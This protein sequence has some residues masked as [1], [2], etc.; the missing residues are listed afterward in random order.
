MQSTLVSATYSI[1]LWNSWHECARRGGRSAQRGG[2]GGH[3]APVMAAATCQAPATNQ[4]PTMA[5]LHEETAQ[6]LPVIA[7]ALPPRTAVAA[8]RLLH[9]LILLLL[10]PAPVQA[11]NDV[12][13]DCTHDL[14]QERAAR[15]DAAA[16][17]VLRDAVALTIDR[18]VSAG[19]LEQ[20]VG[21]LAAS[22]A[23]P[24]A[25]VAPDAVVAPVVA[26]PAPPLH[27]EIAADEAAPLESPNITPSDFLST[28]SGT[29]TAVLH[30]SVCCTFYAVYQVSD[31][32]R[33]A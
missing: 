29:H 22:L 25:V 5:G 23:A 31:L 26:P 3:L 21:V 17:A 32:L 10:H 28:P 1:M 8:L 11:C 13:T 15:A 7:C 20:L 18:I 2:E 12:N 27:I 24:E 33:V 9:L 16:A 4:A 19:R 14:V 30:G 6:V